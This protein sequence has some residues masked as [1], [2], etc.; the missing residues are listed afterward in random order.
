MNRARKLIRK[1]KRRCEERI[2]RR[3]KEDPKAYY[4]YATSKMKA[5]VSVGPLEDENGNIICDDKKMVEILN[6]YFSLVYTMERL[7]NITDARLMF[8]GVHMLEEVDLTTRVAESEVKSLTP[9]PGIL[10]MPILT[11]GILEKPTPTPYDSDS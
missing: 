5:K 1:A 9:T 2:T 10:K 11:P 8:N 6:S 7:E 4:K 3:V